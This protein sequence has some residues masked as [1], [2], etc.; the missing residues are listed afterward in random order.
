MM[1]SPQASSVRDVSDAF[2]ADKYE[3]IRKLA[4]IPQ[5]PRNPNKPFT[6]FRINDILNP[7]TENLSTPRK[8][9]KST[10]KQSNNHH[11]QISNGNHKHSSARLLETVRHHRTQN[12]KHLH[13]K[14]VESKSNHRVPPHPLQHPHPPPPPMRIVRPWDASPSPGKH[15]E[16][17]S[18]ADD[19]INVDEDDEASTSTSSVNLKD[20]SPLDALMEMANKTFQG[21]E[22]SEAAGRSNNKKQHINKNR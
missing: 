16:G 2:C 5:P 20:V 14:S 22:T 21:L 7:E 6:S 9:S 18:D 13:R 3:S 1:A 17:S 4:I 15:S 8:T 11:Q 10:S 19:E 12:I